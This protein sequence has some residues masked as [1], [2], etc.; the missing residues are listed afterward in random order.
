MDPG[1]RGLVP[2]R[3]GNACEYC[4]MP[5]QATPHVESSS[6]RAIGERQTRYGLGRERRLT[7]PIRKL[8]DVV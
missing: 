6:M 8:D 3:A 1:A 5:Q 7:G 4:H 2:T